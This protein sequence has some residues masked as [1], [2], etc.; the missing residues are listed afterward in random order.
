MNPRRIAISIVW[1]GLALMFWQGIAFVVNN[2]RTAPSLG[3]LVRE[4]YPSFA[5]F[6]DSSSNDYRE[7]TRILAW[8]AFQTAKRSL[9]GIGVGGLSGVATG[10]MVFSLGRS[11]ASA[12]FLLLGLM[13]VPLFSLIPL[14]VF[15]FSGK[16]FGI[17]LYTALAAGVLVAAA[18]FEAASNV[19]L[20]YF[21]RASLEGATRVRI[22]ESVVLPAIIPELLLTFRW[23]LGLTWAFT[24]GA[25][26]LSSSSGCGF[27]VYQSYLYSDV[28]K[29]LILGAVYAILG[30]SSIFLF[31]LATTRLLPQ[32]LLTLR[33]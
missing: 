31:D 22:L 19:P 27:L 1:I 16:E 11:R 30:Y 20:T 5:I 7:A 12:Q 4:S 8:H 3:N 25:E 29:L 24:L 13:N 14:F 6:G 32:Q 2:N 28:G 10:L 18:T 17:V 21:W 15:W 9:W 26:Y 23:V 33:R